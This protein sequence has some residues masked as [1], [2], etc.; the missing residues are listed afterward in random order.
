[1]EGGNGL[2][3]IL[4]GKA[5]PSAKLPCAFPASE[6]H[7]P[8]FDKDARSIEYGHYHGYRLMDRDGHVP[9]FPFGFGLS[10]T[11][12][13]YGDLRLDREEIEVDGAVR[14]SAEITNTG[15]VA[16]EEVT[17]LYVGYDGSRVERPL[18][19]LKGFSKVYLA[20]GEVKRVEFEVRAAQLGYYDEGSAGWVVEPIT[21]TA[22]VGP[23]SRG[24]DLLSAQFRIRG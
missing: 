20:P 17:Q 23:S 5:N 3:D 13:A 4:F 24:E 7:L 16:G 1:M 12:Y 9:A 8:F 2:A 22:F 15:N 10:Y 14:V 21:Y 6:S 18:R 19:E 11:T